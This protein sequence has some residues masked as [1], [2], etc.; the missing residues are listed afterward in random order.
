MKP[1]CHVKHTLA[2]KQTD[3]VRKN[4]VFTK[5]TDHQQ[6]DFQKSKETKKL[7]PK[8]NRAKNGLGKTQNKQ[9]KKKPTKT[10]NKVDNTTKKKGTHTQR[11][12][13]K[14]QTRK[15]QLEIKTISNTFSQNGT[16]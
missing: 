12:P 7:T 5:S 14:L 9:N 8:K 6:Q 4:S 10:K 16:Q 11:K 2:I 15:R 13:G 3:T 1:I